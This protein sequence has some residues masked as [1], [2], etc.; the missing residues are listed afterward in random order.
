MTNEM[1]ETMA[2][3]MAR[4]IAMYK[5][6]AEEFKGNKRLCPYYSEFKGLEQACKIF[7]IEYNFD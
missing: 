2:K 1:L 6:N 7:G 5:M 3:A 4:K